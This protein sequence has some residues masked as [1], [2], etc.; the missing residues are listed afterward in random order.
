MLLQ[1][2]PGLLG[3]SRPS[4]SSIVPPALPACQ[5]RANRSYPDK[6]SPPPPR[7]K[8]ARIPF[9]EPSLLAT[10][11]PRGLRLPKRMPSESVLAQLL[12]PH[13]P[14][15][16]KATLRNGV[17]HKPRFSM[18]KQAVLRKTAVLCGID[19][20]SIGLPEKEE[21]WGARSIWMPEGRGDVEKYKR[22]RFAVPNA[23]WRAN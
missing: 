1:R 15:D 9:A 2:L 16:F 14:S 8:P 7:R 6:K 11:T 13:P 23:K 12:V 5:S 18:R 10:E 22:C 17:W 3:L 21:K 20:K 19:P 4:L